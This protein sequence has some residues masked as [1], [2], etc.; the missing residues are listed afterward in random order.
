VDACAAPAPETLCWFPAQGPVQAGGLLLV[1]S[2]RPDLAAFMTARGTDCVARA[3]E[4]SV[5]V[6]LLRAGPAAVIG[7]AGEVLLGTHPVNEGLTGLSDGTL[8]SVEVTAAQLDARCIE[9][10]RPA[11][12][13]TLRLDWASGSS[14]RG[15]LDLV[16][17][18]GGFL[19]GPFEIR[20][21]PA[22]ADA[23]AMAELP[24]CPIA[25]YP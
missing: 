3:R 2:A 5:R 16:T 18:D 13:G 12:T 22:A 21:C 7:G 24:Y 1:L 14:V 10:R 19:R 6:Q 17:D 20:T 4:A 25:C 23:C 15:E 8:W 11:V 9:V